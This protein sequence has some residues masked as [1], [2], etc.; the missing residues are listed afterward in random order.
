VQVAPAVAQR[1]P[2]GGPQL[3]VSATSGWFFLNLN[4]NAAAAGANPPED[5]AAAQAWVTV[6]TNNSSN[7]SIGFAATPY[8]SAC[9]ARHGGP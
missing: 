1:V 7:R 3:P 9:A 4:H 8:D 2:V 5:P 6:L